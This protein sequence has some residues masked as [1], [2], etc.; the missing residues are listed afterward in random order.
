[1]QFILFIHYL[2]KIS[3]LYELINKLIITCKKCNLSEHTAS[4]NGE[5]C[6]LGPDGVVRTSIGANWNMLTGFNWPVFVIIGVLRT[7]SFCLIAS[8]KTKWSVYRWVIWGPILWHP[9]T[10]GASKGNLLSSAEQ[11]N[12]KLLVHAERI[13]WT[14]TNEMTRDWLKCL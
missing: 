14:L 10:G 6:F 4:V 7:I 13:C 11:R 9:I 1:M 2:P 3:E 8:D 5:T 12:L